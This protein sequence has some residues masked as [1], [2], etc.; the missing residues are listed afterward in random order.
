MFAENCVDCALHAFAKTKTA[1]HY[2]LLD[3]VILL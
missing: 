2:L 3:N 1:N